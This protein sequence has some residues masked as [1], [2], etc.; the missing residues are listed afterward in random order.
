[1]HSK[2]VDEI[3]VDTMPSGVRTTPQLNAIKEILPRKD[4]ISPKMIKVTLH[5]IRS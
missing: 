3:D 2:N 5:L 1:M 4:L